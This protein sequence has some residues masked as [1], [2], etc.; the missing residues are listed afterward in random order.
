MSNTDTD[1]LDKLRA[2]RDK[3]RAAALAMI[4][5]P[6]YDPES[7]AIKASEERAA[8][9]DAQIERLA[10]VIEQQRNADALDG[11]LAAA[12]RKTQQGTPGLEVRESLGEAFVRSEQFAQYRGR[13][14]SPQ[15]EVDLDAT[16]ARAL[17]TTL[18]A[19]TTAGIKLGQTSVD[20]TAPVAP[21]PLL[22]NMTRLSVSTNAV[23][24]VAWAKTAGGA[25]VVAEG[26][27]KPS[28]EWAPTVTS[29][30]LDTIAVYTQLTRQLVE[31]APAVRGLI[32]QELVR[33]VLRAEEAAAA[34]ALVA[35]PVPTLV[36]SA[37]AGD[38]LLEMIRKGIGSIQAIGYVPGVVILNPADWAKLDNIVMSGTLNGPA[39]G[40]SFWGLTPIASAAQPVGTATVGDLKTAMIQFFRSQVGLYVTDSHASTFTSNI[41]TL[42]A[43]RR[44]LA[45]VVRPQALIEVSVGA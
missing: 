35:A 8:Q 28:A 18:T 5:A 30:T 4:E 17:P 13:G 34:A 42:L 23:E 15:F 27:A 45:A 20:T 36:G 6:D 25:A 9:L 32:D 22:D 21:T 38:D 16:Q 26:A 41:F 3:H 19:I 2:E 1:V 10:K 33:D 24:F 7:E 31:D 43:E 12:A 14:T 29:D 40:Q 44:A 11:S 37:A 39:I